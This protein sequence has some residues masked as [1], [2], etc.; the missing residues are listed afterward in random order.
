VEKFRNA[1]SELFALLGRT[2]DADAAQKLLD[3][4]A[5]IAAASY[6]IGPTAA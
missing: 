5:V 6:V 1:E 3:Q 2:S 4:I